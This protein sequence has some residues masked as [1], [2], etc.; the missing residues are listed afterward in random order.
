MEPGA[1][2]QKQLT[3]ILAYDSDLQYVIK[4][5][6]D[7]LK[8]PNIAF[9]ADRTATQCDRLLAAACCLSVCLSVCDAVHSDS[10]GWCTRLKVV[11]T[12]S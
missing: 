1:L 12:Y 3:I 8:H 9:L 5:T 11:P 10:Q 7:K 6:Y 4:Q 2:L